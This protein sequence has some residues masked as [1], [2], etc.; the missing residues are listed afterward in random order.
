MA[1]IKSKIM[2]AAL[3]GSNEFRITSCNVSIDNKLPDVHEI[4]GN[5]E[6]SDAYNAFWTDANAAAEVIYVHSTFNESGHQ[7]NEDLHDSDPG[8]RLSMINQRRALMR[9]IT[10]FNLK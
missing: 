10:K 4:R 1:K 7:N 8:V 3:Y 6:V 9:I 2:Q 5:E